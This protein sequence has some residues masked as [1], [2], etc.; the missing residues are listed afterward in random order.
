MPG[1]YV[2]L[3]RTGLNLATWVLRIST[4]AF[5][6]ALPG[7]IF[8]PVGAA[9]GALIGAVIGGVHAN[10]LTKTR[11]YPATAKS[12]FLTLVDNTWSLVNTMVGAGFLVLNLAMGNE[13]DPDR[14]EERSSLVLRNGVMRG[15]ATTI[16]PV[17]A[18]T[19]DHL[20]KHEAVHVFQARLFGPL[21]Y[22]I[23]GLS[24]IV[25]TI[26]PYW[27][28]YHDHEK[29]PITNF[30]SYFQQGVYPH[31]WHEEWAYRV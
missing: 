7:L 11:C 27:L 17:E 12:W 29:R 19:N 23:V 22:P 5:A 30:A 24:Y 31:T 6:L 2:H 3:M 25:C 4:S 26:F 18:G 8:G 1:L 10:A 16:G 28:L 20:D 15:Y 9:V 14:C 21:F 13:L